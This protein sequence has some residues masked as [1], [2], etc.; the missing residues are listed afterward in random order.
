MMISSFATTRDEARVSAIK[1]QIISAFTTTA[2][3]DYE[4]HIDR[5]IE[6]L[7]RHLQN[8]APDVNI[9]Q[10]TI[11]FA[12]DTICRIAF[13]DDQGFMDKQTD[14]GN[15]LEGARQ[16]FQHWHEWQSL[17]KLEKLLYKNRFAS[18]AQGTSLLA[19][20]AAERLQTRVQMGGLGA[21]SDLLDRYLQ[22]GIRDPETFN[23]TTLIGLII[24][25][26]HAG[27]ET[28]ASSLNICLYHLL[29]NPSALAALRKEL[30]AANLD[31][32]PS[33]ASVNRLRYLEAVFK[34]SQRMTPL[35]VDPIERDVP[36][37]GMEISGVYIPGGTTVAVN[38]HAL[39][40][41]PTIWGDDVDTYRPERWLEAD[42]SQLAKME[43]ANLYFSAGRRMC[44]GQH[45]AWIEMKKFLPELLNKFDVSFDIPTLL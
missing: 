44:V 6:T 22:A 26:I 13:S 36:A 2:I 38:V 20:L 34:E 28:T 5:N 41:D 43:R 27:A 31:T 35:L 4:H 24:S 45:V 3:L 7:M 1:K 11:F 30:D 19:K 18:R 21:H 14:L 40:R 10:W 25:T 8:A 29:R 23:Q 37:E 33:W 17:P 16:R 9:A 32:P 39:N 42:E 12:F 15:T